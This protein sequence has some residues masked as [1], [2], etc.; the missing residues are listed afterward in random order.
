[1]DTAKHISELLKRLHDFEVVQCQMLHEKVAVDGSGHPIGNI[2]DDTLVFNRVNLCKQSL[3]NKRLGCAHSRVNLKFEQFLD[4]LKTALP[5]C[6]SQISGYK[7]EFQTVVAK[8]YELDH[9]VGYLEHDI[10]LCELNIDTCGKDKLQQ[11]LRVLKT[12][13]G[14][15]MTLLSKI[16]SDIEE[17]I[18]VEMN[19]SHI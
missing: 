8:I 9:K 1:M 5:N 3:R 11:S 7:T 12:N 13:H 16:K 2:F 18:Y 19:Y 10:A 14:K 6:M 15:L 17:L 4:D